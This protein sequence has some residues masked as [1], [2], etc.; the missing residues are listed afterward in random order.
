MKDERSLSHTK[1]K[2][3]YHVVWI[4]KYRKKFLYTE[5]IYEILLD[6]HMSCQMDFSSLD[7]SSSC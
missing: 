1:W 3:K 2:C 4:P 6:I 7:I 5:L